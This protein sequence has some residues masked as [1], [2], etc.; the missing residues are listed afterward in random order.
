M[1]RN[2]N[3][4][5]WRKKILSFNLD[6]FFDKKIENC[7]EYNESNFCSNGRACR[8]SHPKLLNNSNLLKIFGGDK[9]NHYL[10]YI[11]D[12]LF[13]LS[14]AAI[15]NCL[16]D[17]VILMLNEI[18]SQ[19][20]IILT[21]QDTK[22][23]YS[24]GLDLIYVYNVLPLIIKLINVQKHLYSKNE[25]NDLKIVTELDSLLKRLDQSKNSWTQKEENIHNSI[26]KTTFVSDQE[27]FIENETKNL[28]ISTE[29]CI[30]NIDDIK[31]KVL[32]NLISIFNSLIENETAFIDIQVF[33][34]SES[35]LLLK[36]FS[37]ID[38][39]LSLFLRPDDPT[40]NPLPISLVDIPIPKSQIHLN[41]SE[42]KRLFVNE[43][44]R[45]KEE[46]SHFLQLSLHLF[47]K[48]LELGIRRELNSYPAHGITLLE[49]IKGARIPLI[50]LMHTS[51]KTKVK[52]YIYL[53]LFL[54]NIFDINIF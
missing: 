28:E 22:D 4:N 47:M 48:F 45:L 13:V 27:L 50:K 38:L 29:S 39:S 19:A 9:K 8:K 2:E 25:Q 32:S 30:N 10:C 36:D 51:S 33:G 15:I 35:R 21:G 34:S 20:G 43:I 54:S 7:N 37:D 6:L 16:D 44:V 53:S 5:F 52:I 1:R 40:K 14:K 23:Y 49:F 42:V 24:Y 11:K 46:Q 26:L 3:F 41:F 31:T 12:L 18:T 17:E